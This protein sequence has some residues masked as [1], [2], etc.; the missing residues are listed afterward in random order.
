[1]V[2]K[3]SRCDY[4]LMDS[5][6]VETK[7]LDGAGMGS[8][9]PYPHA[10]FHDQLRMY[11]AREYPSLPSSQHFSQCAGLESVLKHQHNLAKG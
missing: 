4:I 10:R 6:L 8:H 9:P 5:P 1:M 3:G 11:A 7:E 2:S